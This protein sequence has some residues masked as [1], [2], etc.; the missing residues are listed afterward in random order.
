M[1]KVTR[2]QLRECGGAWLKAARMWIQ[3]HCTNGDSVTWGSNTVLQPNL[4]VRD[5]EDLAAEV[6][7]AVINSG[8]YNKY[9]QEVK[10][11]DYTVI[12]KEIENP[13][14]Y[15]FEKSIPKK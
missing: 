8:E 14:N 10:L 5:I 7:A 2:S 3:W 9:P 11:Y 12:N 6:A 4:T 1:N 13:L 15:S